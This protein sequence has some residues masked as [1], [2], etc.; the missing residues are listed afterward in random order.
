MAV[1]SENSQTPENA[2]AASDA[3]QAAG[4]HQPQ[5]AT[6]RSGSDWEDLGLTVAAVFLSVIIIVILLRKLFLTSS[7]GSDVSMDVDL[8]S[9]E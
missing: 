1:Q 3:H 7:N 4:P 9:F 2:P 8:A 5:Q 6:T